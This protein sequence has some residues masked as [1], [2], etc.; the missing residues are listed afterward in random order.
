MS[1]PI[2]P[3]AKVL[4]R[5]PNEDG[6]AEVETLWAT[7]LGDDRYQL[8]N[9]PFYAYSV[10]WQDIVHA[11]ISAEEGVPTFERLPRR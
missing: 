8:D 6:T 5:V 9:S 2:E 4:F 1:E 3:K 7:P 11:P 10:S